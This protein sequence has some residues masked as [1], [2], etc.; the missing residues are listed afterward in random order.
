MRNGA[1][2]E[3]PAASPW[4]VTEQGHVRD[5]Q[6]GGLVGSIE[7]THDSDEWVGIHGGFD[8]T[9]TAVGLFDSRDEAASAEHAYTYDNYDEAE[10]GYLAHPDDGGMA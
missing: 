4:S 9:S 2:N 5:R 7:Q 8:G 1:F 6:L 3:T 10:W